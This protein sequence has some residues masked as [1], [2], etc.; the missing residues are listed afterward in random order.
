MPESFEVRWFMPAPLP[1]ALREWS[2]DSDAEV[3][4]RDDNYFVPSPQVGIK[5]RGGE[6]IELKQLLEERLWS[7]SQMAGTAQ[8]WAKWTL[9]LATP[10]P[11]E[12]RSAA[13]WQL[14][15]K[16][17]WTQ[18]YEVFNDDQV[19][20][21]QRDHRAQEGC[22]LEIVEIKYGSDLSRD[23]WSYGLESFGTPSLVERNF[24]K[25]ASAISKK[26]PE[27]FRG[28][29]GNSVSYPMWLLRRMQGHS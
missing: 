7:D 17:R 8:R 5:V 25:V 27:G 29:V 18:K 21:V 10:T 13:E 24:L 22:K 11:D 28:S 12:I 23:A 14:I 26:F 16:T 2:E 19:V 9:P 3:E 4:D 6:K 15:R 20:R 1:S